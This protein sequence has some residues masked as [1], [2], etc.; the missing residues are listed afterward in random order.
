[1]SYD[2]GPV[3]AT[4]GRHPVPVIRRRA[5]L[6]YGFERLQDGYARKLGA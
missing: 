2:I 6:R 3:A 4:A 5:A 1:M